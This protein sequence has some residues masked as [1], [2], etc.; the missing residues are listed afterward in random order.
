MLVLRGTETHPLDTPRTVPMDQIV[1]EPR[2]LACAVCEARVTSSAER[3]AVAGAHEHVE[4]NPHGYAFRIGCFAAAGNLV[5]VGPPER[6]WTWF[7]GYAWQVECCAG[8][9]AQLGWVFRA[10]AHQFHGLILDRLVEV[11]TARA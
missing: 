2:V 11:G 10:A 3:I 1:D 6:F 5:S 8:C 4:V 9:G 7:P